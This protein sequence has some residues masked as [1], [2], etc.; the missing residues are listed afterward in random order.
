MLRVRPVA[1]PYDPRFQRGPFD[2]AG[3]GR[4]LKGWSEGERLPFHII[5][6]RLKK[7]LE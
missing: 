2:A 6:N 1:L 7:R 3:A 4:L 5:E